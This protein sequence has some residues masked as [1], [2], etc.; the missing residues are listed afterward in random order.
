[1]RQQLRSTLDWRLW[2]FEP[3]PVKELTCFSPVF[4]RWLRKF[5]SVQNFPSP[6]S[7]PKDQ[8]H[9]AEG[10]LALRRYQ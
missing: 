4:N 7:T 1:M 3:R 6:N 2:G 9:C 5:D 10:L 8:E